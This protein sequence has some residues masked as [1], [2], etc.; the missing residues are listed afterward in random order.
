MS[1]EVRQQLLAIDVA[2]E[3]LR[4]Q[5]DGKMGHGA[6]LGG[7][8]VGGIAQDKDVGE[9]VGEKVYLSTGE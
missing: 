4:E 6:G 3:V 1:I 9:A 7:R 5:V 8:N 2:Q